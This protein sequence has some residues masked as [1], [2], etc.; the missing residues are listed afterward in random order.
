VFLVIV[1]L[2]GLTVH[3]F[4]YL[5]ARLRID[6]ADYL[7]LDQYNDHRICFGFLTNYHLFHELTDGHI[8]MFIMRHINNMVLNA[9]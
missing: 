5:I 1:F 2:F 9:A 8:F 3:Q 7:L 6:H 4:Y